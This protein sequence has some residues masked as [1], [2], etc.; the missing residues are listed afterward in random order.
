MYSYARASSILRKAK[1]N[2]E[3]YPEEIEHPQEIKL[4]KLMAKYQDMVEKSSE[5]LSPYILARYSYELALQFNQFYR[6]CPVIKSG[7]KLRDTRLAIVEA[8][9][10]LQGDLMEMLGLKII[11]K[12]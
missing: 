2:G 10:R 8:Y 1:W 4:I 11:E 5:S 9:R 6:D 3:F 7:G 12:M